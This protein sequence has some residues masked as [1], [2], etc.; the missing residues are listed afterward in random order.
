MSYRVVATSPLALL[1]L[2]PELVGFEPRESLVLVA[3]AGK[4]SGGTFRVD[5]PPDSSESRA[6][7]FASTVTGMLCRLREVDGVLPVVYTDAS[8]ATGAPRRDVVDAIV[9]AASAA[10][11]EVRDPLYV[12]S[13][14]WGDYTDEPRPIDEL[15]AASSLRALDPDAPARGASPKDQAALPLTDPTLRQRTLD[16]LTTWKAADDVPDPL[17]VAEYSLHWDPE[18]VGPVA[19]A[20]VASALSRPPLRDVLLLTWC[21]GTKVGERALRFQERFQRGEPVDDRDVELAL[22]GRGA[23]GRP[24]RSAVD[25]ANTLLRH[26]AALLPEADRAPALSSLAWLNWAL[27]ASSVAGEYTLAARAAD[28]S[29]GFAE[30]IEEMLDRGMLPDWA[31]EDKAPANGRRS[32]RDAFGR[33]RR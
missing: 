6:A 7:L 20:L 18:K 29:Y 31:F 28:R 2:V 15:E 14:G 11:F 5:L 33:L 4:V 1:A 21:W 27:G 12:A 30:L 17:W 10:G 9:R 22:S 26:V 3:F 13:D 19:A 32:D 23:L 24:D 16:V 25:R 8:C